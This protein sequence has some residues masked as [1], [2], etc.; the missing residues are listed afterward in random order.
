MQTEHLQKYFANYKLHDFKAC[1]T[2]AFGQQLVAVGI[3]QSQPLSLVMLLL[4]FNLMLHF[5]RGKQR[6]L[7]V[8]CCRVM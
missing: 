8:V 1:L 4:L 2:T 7:I 6:W 3:K 5:T